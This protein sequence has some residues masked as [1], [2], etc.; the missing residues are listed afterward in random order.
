MYLLF[1]KMQETL[2]ILCSRPTENILHFR[3]GTADERV[4]ALQY[5]H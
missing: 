1:L 5:F 3:V 2:T 4:I